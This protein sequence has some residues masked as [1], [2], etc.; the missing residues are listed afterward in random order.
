MSSIESLS[1]EDTGD[2]RVDLEPP[3]ATVINTASGDHHASS[4][5]LKAAIERITFRPEE[6]FTPNPR[7]E[8][9]FE[10][11]D[12]KSISEADMYILVEKIC[13]ALS[14]VDKRP[15]KSN[16]VNKTSGTGTITSFRGRCSRTGVGK[17]PKIGRDNAPCGCNASFRMR[18]E[19]GSLCFP[20]DNLTIMHND[21][22]TSY[23]N[24]HHPDC[25]PI[26]SESK[27]HKR[28]ESLSTLDPEQQLIKQHKKDTSN[29]LKVQLQELRFLIR[30]DSRRQNE[31]GDM[32][33]RFKKED[34][35]GGSTGRKE[36]SVAYSMGGDMSSSVV[37]QG[38]GGD[39]NESV[40]QVILDLTEGGN[41]LSPGGRKRDS[42]S[43]DVTASYP[44]KKRLKKQSL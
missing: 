3:T 30:S 26:L 19:D 38:D 22:I 10:G 34:L 24:G 41:L 29:V 32:I 18:W 12:I 9:L 36:G 17:P 28:H 31:I 4:S 14:Q 6:G 44:A 23:E 37:D 40:E 11:L 35:R 39:V 25:K 42:D 1:V 27:A 2:I 5:I 15:W 13:L 33:E 21:V 8:G 20:N 7:Q 43:E 16:G